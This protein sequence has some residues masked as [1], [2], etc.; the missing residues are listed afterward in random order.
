MDII[1][2]Q[3]SEMKNLEIKYT[4]AQQKILHD[5]TRLEAESNTLKSG[6]KQIQFS[7]ELLNKN[8]SEI[9]LEIAQLLSQIS[10]EKKD[11][12]KITEELSSFQKELIILEEKFKHESKLYADEVKKHEAYQSER[13]KKITESV[14]TSVEQINKILSNQIQVVEERRK[15]ASFRESLVALNVQLTELKTSIDAFDYKKDL[16]ETINM[17]FASLMSELELQKQTLMQNTFLCKEKELAFQAR[18]QIIKQITELEERK[19]NLDTMRKLF[20]ANGFVNYVSTIYL[21]NLCSVA[22]ER[23]LK[24][25]KNT[26]KIELNAEN[27]FNVRDFMNEGKLRSIKTLSG[28]QSFQAALSLALALSSSL[29]QSGKKEPDFFFID[30][31]FGS[32]D[33]A[34]LQIV[35]ET[36]R[37]LQKEGKIVGII[38]HVEELKEE[39]TS[40]IS[41]QKDDYQGSYIIQS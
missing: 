41:A 2:E 26:L 36:L 23:F 21:Q 38:S 28:G 4:Q 19:A 3:Q 37:S 39:I 30:E 18:K 17:Q 34:S 24:F 22:N 27:N 5:I 8:T 6:F 35:L 33:K 25:T 20:T 40:F 15:I 9:E 12:L 16:H 13:D 31:G 14:F 7:D 1:L 29:I 10:Q 11:F 32:Q